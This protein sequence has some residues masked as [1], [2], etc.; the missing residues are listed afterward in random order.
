MTAGREAGGSVNACIFAGRSEST[1]PA[2][3]IQV[4]V[5]VDGVSAVGENDSS[6]ERLAMIDRRW[7]SHRLLS[8]IVLLA[9]HRCMHSPS[10][11]IAAVEGIKQYLVI[12]RTFY[13]KHR[14]RSMLRS[15]CECEADRHKSSPPLIHHSRF[16][17][18][19]T[20][21]LRPLKQ[22]NHDEHE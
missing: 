4:E 17:F 16:T 22:R 11:S 18:C 2:S 9:H 20:P 19:E 10:T 5:V 12:C 14:S 15:W 1:S 8:S 7:S 3:S 6:R 21:S 13:S